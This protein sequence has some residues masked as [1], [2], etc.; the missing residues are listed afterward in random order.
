MNDDDAADKFPSDIQ[1]DRFAPDE[2][3]ERLQKLNKKSIP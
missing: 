2:L 3:C 1:Y